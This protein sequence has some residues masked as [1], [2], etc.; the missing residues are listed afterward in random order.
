MSDE[1][2]QAERHPLTT[3]TKAKVAALAIVCAVLIYFVADFLLSGPD[4]RP[5]TGPAAVVG[6]NF[7]DRTAEFGI[8]V[9]HR[10]G[11]DR[12]TGLDEALGSG[13]CALDFDNDGWMDL[14][15][16]N[17]TGDTRYYG[18]PH[19]WLPSRGHRLLRNIDGQRFVDVTEAA[20]LGVATHGLGCVA[21]D[22]DNDGDADLFVTN[23]GSN[24]LFR[25][26]GGG[27]FTD[28]TQE[29]G[30]AGDGLH[31]AAA[32]ADVDGD[33]LLDLYVGRL[34]NYVK[35]THTYE[36]GSQFR[37]DIPP[38]FNS[39]L[40]P[41]QPN[42]L[43]RNRGNLH[44][45]DVTET[46][47]V[48]D[49]DGRTLAALWTDVNAD[50]R[51]DLIVVNAAGTGSTTG[52]LNLGEWRF[53]PLGLQ[54]RIES[55]VSFHGIASGD[56]DNDGRAELLMTGASGNQ[57]ALLFD[58][59]QD[60]H[61]ATPTFLDKARQW[62]L[63]QEKYAAFVP[64]SPTLADFNNDGWPDVLIANGQLL[65]DED[66]PHVTVGQPKQLWLNVGNGKLNEFQ[67]PPLSP[68]LDRQSARSMAVADFNNDGKLD[69]YIAHNNDLGQLLINDSPQRSQWVGVR[70]VDTRGNRDAVGAR[71][72]VTTND[73]TQTR[74]ATKGSG[75]LSDGDPR[76]HF[77]LG[78]GARASVVVHW[79]DGSKSTY[80][81]VPLD[82][83]VQ[84]SRRGGLDAYVAARSSQS[85]VLL[86]AGSDSPEIRLEYFRGVAA[87]ESSSGTDAALL[88]A[89]QDRSDEVRAGVVAAVAEHKSAAGLGILLRF[90]EDKSD[91]VASQAVDAVCAYEEEGV[92]RY[93]LRM[94][95]HSSA[96]VRRHVADC[97]TGYFNSF[98]EQQAV[99]HRKYLA[100]PYLASLLSDSDT[101]VRIAAARALGASER[102][103][104]V[105]PL[106]ELLKEPDADLQGEVVRALGLIRD[107]YAVPALLSKSAEPNVSPATYA[108][109]FIAL[110]RLSY[111][112]LDA[113][114]R[115]FAQ[116][117]GNFKK[118]TVQTRLA[119]LLGILDSAE[120][121]VLSRDTIQRHADMAYRSGGNDSDAIE[122]YCKI[123]EKNA[124]ASTAS[125]LAALLNHSSPKVRAAAYEASFSLQPQK[126]ATLVAAALNDPD[127]ALRVQIL[128]RV[129]AE[130]QQLPDSVFLDALRSEATRLDAV[131]AIGRV[132]SDA[133]AALLAGWVLD[134]A[135]PKDLRIAALQV[136]GRSGR[137]LDLP[138]QWFAAGNDELRI[139]LLEYETRRLP[140]IFVAKAP[141]AFLQKYLR[142]KSANV[143][144]ATFDFLLKREE[145]WAKQ[146]VV[147]LLEHADASPQLRRHVLEALPDNY[148]HGGGVLLKMAMNRAEPLRLE[149]L[150]QLY[151]ATDAQTVESLV[152][153]AQDEK[154]E[155]KVRLLASGA[156]PVSYR[157][158]LLAA[159][160]AG[161]R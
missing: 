34:I 114:L 93:L 115:N 51:P 136:L 148:L 65:P 96:R 62:Q 60:P 89:L 52:F 3:R 54:A 98:Q 35:G 59:A 28:V 150:H 110:K 78:S 113:M 1:L 82:T 39:A 50:G 40:F 153:I 137:S 20:K 48:K 131:K 118:V 139:A 77:G 46:A 56:L 151:G 147:D 81:N 66:A 159:L 69:V 149:A 84:I 71:V 130:Q 47:G 75:F 23:V 146:V 13:A 67:P 161:N 111:D 124:V 36:S 154:E 85:P 123:L 38:F 128:R 22:F 9:S 107:R 132:D 25:N 141:P 58:T 6:P 109:L 103:R 32:V 122:L 104:G 90:F 102:F 95:A 45:D 10:Q 145:L 73:G 76:L 11:D 142:S 158:A 121:V 17:G 27:S 7:V 99:I 53:E 91:V 55:G 112:D 70:L 49:A 140:S 29:S 155:P 31:T 133:T 135:A 156:L 64:W 105:P 108:Q 79:A 30:L 138:P 8:T 14:F 21:A 129:A 5:F 68:L 83:Y 144:R 72:T 152:A 134:A 18:R 160:F 87:I 12:L 37:Q 61:S 106:L 2:V 127:P 86:T 157:N 41:A 42:S 63:A 116:G 19:W 80:R 119:A 125:P 16:V 26:D 88:P 57:T 117:S 4:V 74:W 94:F 44:F 100:V 43:Y 126:R 143:Q 97:F 101:E 24:I 15:I 120:G 92:T 33:G